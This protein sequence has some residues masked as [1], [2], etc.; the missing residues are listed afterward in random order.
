MIHFDFDKDCCGCMACYN[1]CNHGAISFHQNEEGFLM[2]LV[3]KE[4]CVNC[5]LCDKACPHLNTTTDLSHYSLDS[6]KEKSAYLY[7]SKGKERKDSASGGFVFDVYKKTLEDGGY[8]CGCVWNESMNAEHIFTNN[9]N[10][11]PRLQSSKYVQSYI[12]DTFREIKKA[13]R[14]GKKV[15]FC[16]TPCQTAGLNFYLGKTDRSNLISVCIICHGVPSPGVWN[17]WK[18]IMEKRL[19]G[20]ILFVNMRD[21]SYKGYSQSYIRY[22]YTPSHTP[23]KARYVGMPTYLADPYLFLFTDDLYLRHSCN[24]C[25]YKAENNGADIIVGDYYHSTPKAENLGCSC[26]FAMTSKGDD[27]I[28]SL[29]GEIIPTDYVTIG[30]V[31]NMLWKS[32]NEHPRRKEF[33]ELFKSTDSLD[34]TLFTRFLPFRF[35]IKKWLNQLG[36]F[37]LVRNMKIVKKAAKTIRDH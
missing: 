3:N 34:K 17:R 14:D 30:M 8:I 18:N 5:G 2:P 36:L 16:G 33:F 35:Y 7:F 12:G 6:F 26:L 24:H 11:L 10:D 1:S 15:A 37:D 9:T 25:Q 29:K 32:V 19:K 21:K 4:K 28:K 20:K 31:N 27:F 23:S 13:L 22:Y